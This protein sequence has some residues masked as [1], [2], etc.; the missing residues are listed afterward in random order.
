MGKWRKH[1]ETTHT[2]EQRGQPKTTPLW[3]TY[4]I[5]LMQLAFRRSG[6]YI[7]KVASMLAM[8][9]ALTSAFEQIKPCCC[10]LFYLVLT[11]FISDQKVDVYHY[12]V[13]P[14]VVRNWQLPESATTKRISYIKE[15][16]GTVNSN[17]R[18]ALCR[19]WAGYR[20]PS[21]QGEFCTLWFSETTLYKTQNKR[22]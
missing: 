11:N 20:P 9:D 10:F 7:M 19:P 3:A 1:K 15:C 21:P 16:W 17:S 18:H 4:N 22:C 13:D 12:F 14:C 5:G 2:R 6:K 8:F